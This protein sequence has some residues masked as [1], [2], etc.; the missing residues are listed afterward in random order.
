MWINSVAPIKLDGEIQLSN[1]YMYRAVAY[2]KSAYF[3]KEI[4]GLIGDDIL[5]KSINNVL[6]KNINKEFS[7]KDIIDELSL[8]TKID[9]KKYSEN[10]LKTNNH[11]D[12]KLEPI[13]GK[14]SMRFLKIINSGLNSDIPFEIVAYDSK[15]N[16]L[17]K[18]TITPN[19]INWQ[20]VAFNNDF[21]ISKI[22]IDPL[23]K[24]LQYESHNDIYP[25]YYLPKETQ[26]EITNSVIKIFQIIKDGNKDEYSKC[27]ASNPKNIKTENRIY[28]LS[29]FKAFNIKIKN[30]LVD[31]SNCNDGIVRVIFL[32]TINNG[33][34]TFDL[35][36]K[37]SLVKE[38]DTWK[39]TEMRL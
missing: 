24:I 31:I 34:K 9:V 37:M 38:N 5:F 20:Q 36:G 12:Y 25:D 3:F 6:I 28:F 8:N 11:P 2:N 7:F 1:N 29:K 22:I 14:D 16:I 35:Y 17:D 32:A 30:E 23:K 15:M 21:P 27:L 10:F 33:R 26:L 4:E 13:E 39:F 19:S 18:K